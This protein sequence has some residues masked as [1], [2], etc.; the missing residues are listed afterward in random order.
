MDFVQLNF[1]VYT[2]IIE[3]KTAEC[4]VNCVR[5]LRGKGRRANRDHFKRIM[6]LMQDEHALDFISA[7]SPPVMFD[8]WSPD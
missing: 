5:K 6:Q 7:S 2:R 3:W 1:R 4:R 8:Q